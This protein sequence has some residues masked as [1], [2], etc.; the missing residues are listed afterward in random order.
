MAILVPR[1]IPRYFF[2]TLPKRD[3]ERRLPGYC[4]FYILRIQLAFYTQ[5]AKVPA[6]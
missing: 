4:Q 1:E 3:M 6:V 2:S 5:E